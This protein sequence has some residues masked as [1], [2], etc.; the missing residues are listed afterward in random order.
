MTNPNMRREI[1][2]SVLIDIDCD[3][4]C[5]TFTINATLKQWYDWAVAGKDL[6]EA[7]PDASPLSK[8]LLTTRQCFDCGNREEPEEQLAEILAWQQTLAGDVQ[9][10]ARRVW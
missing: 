5:Q 8:Q 1:S 9:A 3:Y 4:C 7:M 6:S 10:F 2:D